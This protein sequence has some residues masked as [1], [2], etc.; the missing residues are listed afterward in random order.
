[1][2]GTVLLPERRYGTTLRVQEL[3]FAPG[4]GLHE[5]MPALL[6]SLRDH[7]VRTPAIRPDIGPCTEI[8]FMLGRSHPVYDV[9]G[10]ARAPRVE[11]PY[12]WYVRIP[13]LAAFL[14][15]IAPVL[16]KRLAQSVLTGYSGTLVIDLYREAFELRF[17]GGRLAGV[18]PWTRPRYD[19]DDE[20]AGL[21]SPP[22]VFLQ[23]LLGYRS[24]DELR[25][26]F[27]DVGAHDDHRL[28]IG[29]LFPKQPSFVEPLG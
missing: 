20:Y 17:E 2:C 23:L 18:V 22:L 7:A 10:D 19:E 6:R 1:V 15:L 5:L 8:A 25:A 21:G 4:A 24:L 3:W 29:T 16:E 9:L 11:P 13:D 14:R 28:L 26:I 12:A 27:P